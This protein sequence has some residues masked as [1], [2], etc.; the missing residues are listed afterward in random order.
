[1][2]AIKTV[3]PLLAVAVAAL[4]TAADA[5]SCVPAGGTV[6]QTTGGTTA[7]QYEGGPLMACGAFGK[8][9]ELGPGRWSNF[10]D[11][12]NES[13]LLALSETCAVV[14][15]EGGNYRY[16]SVDA[17][18]RVVDLRARASASSNTLPIAAFS[19]Y[20]IPKAAIGPDCTAA[21]EHGSAMFKAHVFGVD[22]RGQT[23]AGDGVSVEDYAASLQG[24]ANGL[25]TVRPSTAGTKLS[26]NPRL[27]GGTSKLTLRYGK[28]GSGEYP[29]GITI[30]AA[31]R[32]VRVST[33]AYAE[34]T[35][36][37]RIAVPVGT[38]VARALR[39][40]RR[41]KVEVISCAYGCRS[42]ARPVTV[43]R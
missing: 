22:A 1:M 27:G 37:Q 17:T 4:P 31:G 43:V 20:S 30:L 24:P 40:A 3:L 26:S 15:R 6:V 21:F 16:E 7:W 33:S 8:P 38:T 39:K 34:T 36:P 11:S 12:S 19:W 25:A 35:N 41:P 29:Q 9:L 32:T 10:F 42:E 14:K 18:V 23:E 28:P 5:A 2:H 13:T